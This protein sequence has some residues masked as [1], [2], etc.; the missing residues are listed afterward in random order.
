MDS[1][2]QEL[3]K[4]E[5][6][7]S[8]SIKVDG[9]IDLTDEIALTNIKP[10]K[11]AK[12]KDILEYL[13]TKME[14]HDDQ[15]GIIKFEDKKSFGFYLYEISTDLHATYQSVRDSILKLIG[16]ECINITVIGFDLKLDTA[17]QILDYI[18][19]HTQKE[20]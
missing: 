12:P 8:K 3:P 20:C 11:R 18:E 9:V 15:Y 7:L 19:I 14:K 5:S 16:K 4:W 13:K 10:M 17:N 6:E 2:Q 1:N